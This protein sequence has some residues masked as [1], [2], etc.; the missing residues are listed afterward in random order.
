MQKKNEKQNGF[1]LAALFILVSALVILS[2]VIDPAVALGELLLLL[3]LCLYLLIASVGNK[4]K[5][6]RRLDEIMGDLKV[7][8][9]RSLLDVPMPV[10]ILRKNGEI[11]WANDKF[12]EVAGVNNLFGKN[13]IEFTGAMALKNIDREQLYHGF[14]VELNENFFHVCGTFTKPD[15]GGEQMLVF[16]WNDQTA[17]RQLQ[18]KCEGA[19]PAIALLMIDSFDE[20]ASLLS[21]NDKATVISRVENCFADWMKNTGGVF[22]SLERGKYLFIC[23]NRFIADFVAAKFDVLD[24]IRSITLQHR[25]PITVSMGIGIEGSSF[26]ENHDYARQAM[27]MALGRGGDQAVIKTRNNFEFYGGKSQTVEKR[28]KVKTRVMAAA[29]SELFDRCSNVLVMGHKYADYDSI[30][31]CVGI[32]RA[33]MVK[34]KPVNIIINRATMLAAP[35]V[36]NL[37]NLPEYNGVFVEESVGQDLIQSRTLLVVCDTHSPIYVES[38]D[39]LE[40]CPSVVV[41]D[42]HR[43]MAE[44]IENAVQF[45]HEPFASSTCEIV[46]ELIQYIDGNA[47]IAKEEAEAVLAGIVLDTKNFYF[48]T[49]FRTFEAAAY[50]RKAGADLIAL[51]RLFKSDYISY[52]RRTELITAAQFYGDNIAISVWD[53]P[54]LENAKIIMSQAADELLNIEAVDASFVLYP[55]GDHVHISARSLGGINV[56]VILE[57]LGGGGHMTTAGAQVKGKTPEVV[58]RLKEAIDEYRTDNE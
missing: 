49:G 16:Y 47:T 24:Q 55:E 23:E 45:Y 12:S 5:I 17:Y 42:H 18:E 32:A 33:A 40:N 36:D 57:K 21:E 53:G 25:I 46:T 7:A 30:G 44:F 20:M 19:K 4:G 56:Q 50:L 58:V 41:I 22:R 1:R 29:L 38:R 26:S 43:K 9:R 15:H 13:I 28:T 39:I 51:K 10:T 14:P 6:I 35:L 34:E 8:S 48:K 31:A 2:F 37:M 11:V 27:D 3:C 52:I 54:M